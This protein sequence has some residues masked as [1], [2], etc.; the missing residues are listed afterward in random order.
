MT[1]SVPPAYARTLLMRGELAP[2]TSISGPLLVMPS[3]QIHRIPGAVRCLGSLD[4]SDNPTLT[5]IEDGLW[6]KNSLVLANCRMLRLIGNDLTV[7][8]ELSPEDDPGNQDLDL[9]NCLSLSKIGNGL[10]VGGNILL[11]GCPTNIVLPEVGFVGKNLYLPKGYTAER[12][13][14]GL[15]ILGT[16]YSTTEH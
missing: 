5:E 4:C 11:S 16:A 7:G 2:G 8:M 9:Q 1:P 15:Q 14:K 3:K 6:V 13:P 12:I 10:R